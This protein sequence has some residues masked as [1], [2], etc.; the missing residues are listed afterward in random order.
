MLALLANV[1]SPLMMAG[2]L[3]LAI[4]NAVI[5]VLEAGVLRAR[6]R[7][8]LLRGVPLMLV[9]NY[10]SMLAGMAVLH[11]FGAGT[12][13][14]DSAAVPPDRALWFMTGAALAAWALTVVL[15]LPMVRWA[16][17]VAST[18]GRATRASLL[19]QTISYVLLVV[20]Y[21]LVSDVSLLTGTTFVPA[22]ELAPGLAHR[23][24]FLDAHGSLAAVGF[25][26]RPPER[27]ATLDRARFEELRRLADDP[28]V[29]SAVLRREYAKLLAAGA[30]VVEPGDVEPHAVD[31]WSVQSGFWPSDGI[32]I[33]RA[34]RSDPVRLAVATPLLSWGVGGATVLPGGVAVFTL[35]PHIVALELAQRRLAVLAQGAS[36]IVVLPK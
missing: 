8:P 10:A 24:H 22:G 35:G 17:G 19:V 25:D 29:D 20:W 16:M 21:A 4:G 7:V 27:I 11:A 5:G 30:P 12:A 18:W 28:L 13:T 15:E 36:P 9:A 1:G 32:T 34:S 33:R 14:F 2:F 3:H 26:G 31:G 6:F 23:V